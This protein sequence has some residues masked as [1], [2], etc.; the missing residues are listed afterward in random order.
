MS[1][2][3]ICNKPSDN[4]YSLLNV[5][6][7]FKGII[8]GKEI[9]RDHEPLVNLIIFQLL[10]I[11]CLYPI[12]PVFFQTIEFVRWAFQAGLLEKPS[13]FDPR[14]QSDVDPRKLFYFDPSK[15]LTGGV[16][17]ILPCLLL[18]LHLADAF[19]KEFDAV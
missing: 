6:A 15:V 11:V 14:G 17:F 2:F 18:G 9:H 4:L 13:A 1:F 3:T 10:T 12:E 8:L 19:A 5:I 7:Q 16:I